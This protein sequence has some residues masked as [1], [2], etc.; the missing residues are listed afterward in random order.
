MFEMFTIGQNT[1]IQT[2]QRKSVASHP[3]SAAAHF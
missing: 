1:H 2:T 3:V